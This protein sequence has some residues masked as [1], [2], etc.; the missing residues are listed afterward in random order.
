MMLTCVKAH[1]LMDAN[2]AG[3]KIVVIP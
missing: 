1:R 2:K 3:G